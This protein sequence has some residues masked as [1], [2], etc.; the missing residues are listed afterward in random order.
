MISAN[1]LSSQWHSSPHV[2]HLCQS[3]VN[4]CL[5]FEIFFKKKTPHWLSSPAAC[6]LRPWS[7]PVGGGGVGG[8]ERIMLFFQRK[9]INCLLKQ[10]FRIGRKQEEIAQNA[11]RL[12]AIRKVAKKLPSNL[13]KA[14]GK[15]ITC[16]NLIIP[17]GMVH[18]HFALCYKLLLPLH[19]YKGRHNTQHCQREIWMSLHHYDNTGCSRKKTQPFIW[20]YCYMS[21]SCKITNFT[22][23]MV[24]EW[25][26]KWQK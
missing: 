2:R 26:T 25:N 9:F 22:I 13:R 16:Q 10:I 15:G 21:N 4:I 1:E 3:S 19:L 5:P 8:G 18:R 23:N 11:K 24:S 17:G 6:I 20:N 7:G 14:L 12:L